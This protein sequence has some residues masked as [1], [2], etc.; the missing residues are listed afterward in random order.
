MLAYG[1]NAKMAIGLEVVLL[2]VNS[3]L[4]AFIHIFY[5][6]GI[7]WEMAAFT[8]LGVLFWARK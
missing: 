5:Y 1:L 2:S 8:M 3:L 4:L 6:G 7:P